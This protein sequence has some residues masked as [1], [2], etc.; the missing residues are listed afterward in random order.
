MSIDTFCHCEAQ[1]AEAIS[2][3][4]FPFVGLL[5]GACPEHYEILRYT[6]NDRERR[7]RNDI[8]K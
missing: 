3:L 4:I 1:S 2:C 6:Q 8:R 7:A 5:R